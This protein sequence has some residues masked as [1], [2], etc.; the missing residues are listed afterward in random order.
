MGRV[1]SLQQQI[2]ELSAE[3]RAELRDWFLEL[4]WK[5]WDAQLE[6]DVRAGRLDALA[7]VAL[8]DHAARKSTSR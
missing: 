5:L 4:D 7:N 8:R 6:Q 1:E 2:Q 3:E